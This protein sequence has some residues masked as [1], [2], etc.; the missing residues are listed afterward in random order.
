MTRVIPGSKTGFSPL[1]GHPDLL[2]G[3]LTDA[4]VGQLVTRTLDPSDEQLRAMTHDLSRF[5]CLEQIERWRRGERT[6]LCLL[7]PAGSLVG[8]FWVTEKSPPARD[9]Y[10]DPEAIRRHAPSVTVAIRLY[11]PLR[12]HGVARAFAERS[13]DVLL[14]DYDPPPSLWF[15]TR[16]DNLAIRALAT[17]FG[18]DEASG[19][20]GGTVIGLRPANR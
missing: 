4:A 12:G 18:F 6:A 2:C 14:R 3:P 20:A 8:I 7:D 19:E 9:D 10:L 5:S 13:L 15:E 11:G 1:P 17:Q 16:A